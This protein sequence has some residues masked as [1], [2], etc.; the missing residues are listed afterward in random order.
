M[1]YPHLFWITLKAY[2][3]RNDSQNRTMADR[4]KDNAELERQA[5]LFSYDLQESAKLSD[6]DRRK[7]TLA[8]YTFYAYH[9][10]IILSH[11]DVFYSD[12]RKKL[13]SVLPHINLYD[14]SNKWTKVSAPITQ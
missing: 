8:I 7:F 5:G 1:V 6:E 10:P 3:V 2:I 12:V 4:Q 11:Q 9:N 13:S 14:F